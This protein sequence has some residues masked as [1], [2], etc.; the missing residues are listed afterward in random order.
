MKSVLQVYRLLLK[1]LLLG[2]IVNQENYCKDIA[3]FILTLQNLF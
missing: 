2:H 3:K 1:F